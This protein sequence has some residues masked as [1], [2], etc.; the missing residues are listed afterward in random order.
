M[1][2]GVQR[3]VRSD[4]GASGVMFT[5]DTESGFGDAVFLTS[6]YGLG[7]AVVEAVNPDEFYLQASTAGRPTCDP[8]ARRRSKATKMV[9][10][11]QRPGRRLNSWMSIKPTGDDSLLVTL[12]SP[13][14]RAMR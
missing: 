4:L 13:S 10:T 14:W 2:A 6:S 9:Y 8:Q 3:M 1:S 11:T 7:E 5:M 12:T